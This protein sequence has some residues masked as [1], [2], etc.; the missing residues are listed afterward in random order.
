MIAKCTALAR[1]LLTLLA[2]AACGGDSSS[3]VTPTTPTTPTTPV[4]P[5]TPANTLL[6]G[7]SL[8][9]QGFPADYSRIGA[10]FDEVTTFGHASVTWNGPWRDDLVLGGN[11]G[12]IPSA[13][14]LVGNGGQSGFRFEPVAVFG[15]RSGT[16]LYI[17][18]PENQTNDWSN[19][20]ARFAFRTM[21]RIYASIY[22]PKF[23][24]LG[25]EN[26]FY[27]EQ[28]PVDYARWIA[29]YN[30][31]YDA[32]KISSPETRVGPVF[33]VE[34]MMGLGTFSGWTTPRTEAFTLHDLARVDVVGLTLYPYLGRAT[35]AD[36]P[37][38]YLDGVL[39]LVGS[40]PIAIT[41]TGWPA[42]STT[43]V[44]WQASETQQTAY[45]SRLT[46]MIAGR[47]VILV[48][49]LFLHPMANATPDVMSTF[50]TVS[51]RTESGA[52]RPIYD[53]FLAFGAT[54]P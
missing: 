30:E 43:T 21:L 38:N 18:V 5:T 45:L 44:A 50:G 20:S 36:V 17:R 10:F 48:N 22:H 14:T 24:F 27:Y 26:D 15:W 35:A 7:V 53:A 11:A 28:D 1:L 52:K 41:E 34:H 29:A 3:A 9:P 25:N 46:A 31:A 2:V 19:T 16:T 51:L 40:L 49:W 42:A 6:R 12:T 33:S 13:A 54:K 23:I 39:S 47:N 4:T 32:I 8:S 37:T